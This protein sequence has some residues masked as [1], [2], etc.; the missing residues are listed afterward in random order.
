MLVRELIAAVVALAVAGSTGAATVFGGPK[1]DSAI[2]PA[3]AL[4]VDPATAWADFASANLGDV[5]GTGI[6]D[7]H[8]GASEVSDTLELYRRNSLSARDVDLGAG[9]ASVPEPMAWMMMIAGVGL[10]GAMLR[11]RRGLTSLN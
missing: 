4:S 11:R 10:A 3:P 8:L 6:R 1:I 9:V 7:A 2:A 5:A